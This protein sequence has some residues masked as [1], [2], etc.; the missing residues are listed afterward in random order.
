M[1][2]RLGLDRPIRHVAPRAEIIARPV[3]AND[4]MIELR[5]LGTAD[6]PVLEYNPR[7]EGYNKPIQKS[8]PSLDNIL[9][10]DTVKNEMSGI[11]RRKVIDLSAEIELSQEMLEKRIGLRRAADKFRRKVAALIHFRLGFCT[12]AL[13]TVLMGAALGVIFRGA[14]LL[15]AIGLSVV[16]L[17]SVAL[18]MLMGRQLAQ[19]AG[20]EAVGIA[21]IWGGLLLVAVADVCILRV[22]VR[23]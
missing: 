15:A 9:L 8:D 16:P 23:R 13:V 18:M 11:T 10:P 12:C 5:L 4:A 19:H 2:T 21:I 17:A 14:R 6:D 7:S 1:E 22:G 3:A 20:T